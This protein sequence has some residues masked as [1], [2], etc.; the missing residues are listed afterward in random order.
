MPRSSVFFEAGG[1]ALSGF[2]ANYVVLSRYFYS[3]VNT[4][5]PSCKWVQGRSKLVTNRL[6]MSLGGG[7]GALYV[8]IKIYILKGPLRGK[9]SVD[10]Q[11]VYSR[12]VLE[13][14][15][16]KFGRNVAGL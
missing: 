10:N 1:L 2:F 8:R 4:I 12:Y 13:K 9:N 7:G 6:W 14:K 11:L 3:V 16:K 5:C 15:S